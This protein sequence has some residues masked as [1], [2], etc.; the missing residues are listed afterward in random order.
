[1]VLDKLGKSLREALRKIARAGYIDAETLETILKEIQRALLAADVKVDL[2]F[3][4]TET[5][6]SRAKDEKPLEGLSPREHILH[7]VYEELTKLLG[8]KESGLKESAK[9]IMLVGLF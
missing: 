4:L 9:K 6:K 8:G 7:V 5:I 2:V 1:M 3:K